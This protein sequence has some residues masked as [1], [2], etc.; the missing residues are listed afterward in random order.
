MNERLRDAIK[1]RAR[2]DRYF[3]AKGVLG[4]KDVNPY[5]H[6][7]FLRALEDKT[8][9]RRMYLK[10][11]GSLKSTLGTVTD[12]VGEALDDPEEFR[13]L[14]VNEIEENAIGFISEIKA[15]FENNDLIH[16]LFP[17][18]IPKRFGG[19]G[20]KWST[21]K[22]CLPRKTTYKEWTWR[23]VGVGSAIVSQ[24]FTHI[25]CDDLIGFESRESAA[26]MRYAIA[27]AKAMEP[28]LVDGDENIIDFIGTRWA[29]YDLY[30]EML[31]IYGDDMSY[32]AREDIEIVPE[33]LSDELLR[34]AGFTEKKGYKDLSKI[35]GTLQPIFP[36]KFSLKGLKRLEN[37][38]PVLYYAQFKN[39][40]IADGIK[41]FDAGKL[42][43]F[44]FDNAGNVVYRDAKTGLLLRW[45]REQLDIVMA[46][47]PNSGELVATDFPSIVVMAL[48]PLDQVYLFDEWA[49]RV[50][51]DRYVEQIFEM[52]ARWWPR[53]YGIEKVAAQQLSFWFNKLRRDRKILI[54]PAEELKPRNRNKAERIRRTLGPIINT[55]RMYVRKSQ[56][57]F[58]HQVRF[59]PDLDND[60]VID[61]AAYC[62]ELF[63]RPLGQKEYEE[64]RDATNR[65]LQMRS[66]RT[67]Y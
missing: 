23:G 5:T 41:D 28:L 2:K 25:K 26:N 52:W 12:S 38:D 20:S 48:S 31:K 7:P 4:Y 65:V 64:E 39:N 40:P 37:I 16:E 57:L 35:R 14:I 45:P 18:L 67:G 32:F 27:Y 10:H 44:D 11:R 62:T 47:D 66:T 58:Q 36:A 53:A 51:P 54:P 33:G 63:I 59:H 1:F 22:A 49:M 24:H 15:H 55:G 61:A 13:G 17:E 30:R 50:Q 9:K 19:P 43:W 8:K 34:E 21:A 6:G 56:G 60:D 29:I 3:L 46:C 42:N